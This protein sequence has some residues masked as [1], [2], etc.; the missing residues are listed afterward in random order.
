MNKKLIFLTFMVFSCLVNAAPSGKFTLLVKD[1]NNIPLEQAEAGILAFL[2]RKAGSGW[3]SRTEKI[4]GLTNDQGLYT[5]KHETQNRINYFARKDGFYP[6]GKIYKNFKNV[7][8]IWGFR[9][10][11]PWNPTLNIVLKE[12]KNPIPLYAATV[13]EAE[14]P[15]LDE[16]VGFDLIKRDW[17]IPNGRGVNNDILFKLV[18]H[19][20]NSHRDYNIEFTVSF[21]NAQDG[22]QLVIDNPDEGSTLR[23][24]H[25]APISGYDYQLLKSHN[26]ESGKT[27]SSKDRLINEDH[28][29]FFR[30]RSQADDQGQL[31]SAL[32]GKTNGPI[33]IGFFSK[34]NTTGKIS[35]TYYLN[36]TP[37]DS[38]L[39]FD[40]KKNLFKNL[41][42]NERV[43]RP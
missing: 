21:P 33:K 20:L 32:Y 9:R 13:V 6:T 38:N 8:G 10:W 24:P 22:I 19:R 1:E 4:S 2:S 7:T 11:Q 39:E 12:I 5:V 35:F 43:G 29:Y 17:V 25:R 30:V 15:K 3:G 27:Y 41:K 18:R 14:L 31:E 26:R 40:V 42:P 37:N 36:P 16:F 23:L 34:P 28:N